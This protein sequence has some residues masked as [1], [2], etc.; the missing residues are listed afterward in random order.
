MLERIAARRSELD[1]LEERLVKELEEVRAEREEL[2]VAERVLHRLREQAAQDEET[3]AP[4]TGQ[5]ADRSVLLVPHRENGLDEEAL[6]ADC[7]RI[8]GAVRAADEPVMAQDVCRVLGVS[9]EARHREALRSKLNRLADRGWLRK[10]PAG[11]FT[12]TL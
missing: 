3:P 12:R 10:T 4:A 5:L 9:T 8:Y 11:R 6:P 7:R 1:T 2:M